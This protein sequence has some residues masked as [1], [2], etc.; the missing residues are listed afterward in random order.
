M[1]HSSAVS[2]GNNHH[3]VIHQLNLLDVI[4]CL[5]D[6][7]LDNSNQSQTADIKELNL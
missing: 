6:I 5:Q 4:S 2:T 3:K 1:Q 7:L